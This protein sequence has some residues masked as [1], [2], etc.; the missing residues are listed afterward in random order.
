MSSTTPT[1]APSTPSPKSTP[2]TT[3]PTSTSASRTT[4]TNSTYSSSSPAP[5][6]SKPP[7]KEKEKHHHHH[8][9]MHRHHH[10]R[11]IKSLQAGLLQS[12]T[13]GELLSPVKSVA[14]GLAGRRGSK[15][16]GEKKSSSGRG[17]AQGQGHLRSRAEDE[18][19]R[20][21]GWEDLRRVRERRR[22]GERKLQ[23]QLSSLQDAA[24]AATRSLDTSY[25]SLLASIPN[26]QNTLSLLRNLAT[27]S[28]ALLENFTT[29]AVP[30]LTLEFET[31]ICTLQENF[32]GVQSERIA[33]LEAR[34]LAARERVKGLGERVEGVRSRVEEWERREREGKRRGRRNIGI[35]WGVLG[36]AVGLFVLVVLYRGWN[37][38]ADGLEEVARKQ[39]SQRM[40]RMLGKEDFGGLIGDGGTLEKGPES[41]WIRSLVSQPTSPKKS[42]E[43]DALL[44]VFDEL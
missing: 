3:K 42:K 29:C 27:Q 11:E 20:R 6:T 5:S 40:E 44:R 23:K 36:T 13:L 14:E 1:H 24:T 25:Y 39:T 31:Q 30:E 26:I 28:Q 2:P 41:R 38:G 16:D 37:G 21:V 43:L 32:D 4:Y 19:R 35:L 18:G 34:M 7:E 10:H 8:T 22:V 33:G 12:T 17:G 15:D 9:H